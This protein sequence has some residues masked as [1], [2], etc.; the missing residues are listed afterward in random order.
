MQNKIFNIIFCGDIKKGKDIESA[1][2]EMAILFKKNPEQITELF[3]GQRRV[4]KKRLDLETAMKYQ[5]VFEKTGAICFIEKEEAT[6]I[7]TPQNIA[8]DDRPPNPKPIENKANT[9]TNAKTQE[10]TTFE[11]DNN[12]II[13]KAENTQPSRIDP[14]PKPNQLPAVQSTPDS[15]TTFRFGAGNIDSDEFRAEGEKKALYWGI[16]ILIFMLLFITTASVGVLTLFILGYTGIMIWIKQSQL[17]G[18]AAKVSETQF[19]K[20]H[21]IA[22][23]SAARLG[24]RLPEVFIR[25]DPNLNAYA[26]G[27]L[28]KKSIVLH[29][30]TVEAMDETELQYIIGHEF[31]HIKCGHTNLVV[32]MN[33]RE[34]IQVPVISQIMGF[35]FLFWSRKAEYTCDR[36]GLMACRDPKSAISAICKLVVGSSLFNQMNIDHLL[37]QRMDIDQNSLSKL[38]ENFSTHP[39]LVKRIHAIQ[40]FNDSPI[41]RRL[42]RK[43]S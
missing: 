34:G 12:L 26:I 5:A 18:S 1:K 29:S 40:D 6:R 36:G 9:I 8:T 23:Q 17:L 35:I 32:L 2:N 24:M 7:N 33:S 19:P 15:K 4:I 43:R 27:F 3:N 10:K 11:L 41:F 14:S 20:I 39:Y 31:S 38:S 16:G 42:I 37:D 25:Q 21:N 30:A 28:G 22:Q 13:E